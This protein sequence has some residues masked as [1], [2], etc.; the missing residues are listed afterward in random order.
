MPP[1]DSAAVKTSVQGISPSPIAAL[2]CPSSEPGVPLNSL[3]WRETVRPGSWRI[4]STG[5]APPCMPFAV[6]YCMMKFEGVLLP[7]ICQGDEPQ[8]RVM[9]SGA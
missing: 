3:R 7:R 9:T 5:S 8:S 4:G 1:T 6:S 2:P